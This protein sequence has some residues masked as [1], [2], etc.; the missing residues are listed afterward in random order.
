[1][2]IAEAINIIWRLAN[3]SAETNEEKEAVDLSHDYIAN[4][5]GD[6]LADEDEDE[7][8]D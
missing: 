3:T 8:D 5:L 4:Y 6:K 7:D 2:K 1:M